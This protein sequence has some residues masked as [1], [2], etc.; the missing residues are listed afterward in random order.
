[1]TS[2]GLSEDT[3]LSAYFPG[4]ASPNSLR[5]E[6]TFLRRREN[7]RFTAKISEGDILLPGLIV[8]RTEFTLGG[9]SKAVR[10]TRQ[11]ILTLDAICETTEIAL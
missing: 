7:N 2:S 10:G 9:G 5:T 11:T 4:L 1:M 6:E 8:T 3:L